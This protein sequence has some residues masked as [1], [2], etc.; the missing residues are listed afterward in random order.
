MRRGWFPKI[1]CGFLVGVGLALGL[2]FATVTGTYTPIRVSADGLTTEYSFGFQVPAQT[3]LVVQLVNASTLAVTNQTL[4]SNYTVTLSKSVPGGH[5][6]FV[7][8]PASGQYVQMYRNIALTQPIDI[9]AGGLFREVQIENALDRNVLLLQQQQDQINRAWLLPIGSGTEFNIPVPE[10]GKFLKGNPTNDGYINSDLPDPSTLVKSTQA[11]AEAAVSDSVYTTPL[12]VK[13]EVQKSGAVSIPAANVAVNSVPT[14]A[15]MLWPT[16][17]APS[18]WL[19]ENGASLSRTTYA[20]LFA[21]IGTMYG[22]ADASHFNLPDSRGKFP[23][24]WDHA[25]AI[26]PDRA[27]RTA[28]SVT[29]A[30]LTAG[31][32]VGTEQA[33]AFKS[34]THSTDLGVPSASPTASGAYYVASASGTSGATGGNETRPVN[35]YRM[36]IIKY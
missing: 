14:G 12:Q 5:V 11:E 20:T 7:T 33:E 31:D 35:M 25:A 3:D 29:G 34:H 1:L 23:R 17:T 9:P 27:T 10:A 21:V 22:T 8:P 18:G 28:P 30:T 16:E 26:D 19:E 6:D 24:V 4:V 15:E 32:H 2:A 13:N 36:M